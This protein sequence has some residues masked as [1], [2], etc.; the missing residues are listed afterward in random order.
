MLVTRSRMCLLAWPHSLLVYYALLGFCLPPAHRFCYRR[1]IPIRRRSPRRWYYPITGVFVTAGGKPV[2]HRRLA[3]FARGSMNRKQ[4]KRPT[5][6]P[7]HHLPTVLSSLQLQR[8]HAKRN[9]ITTGTNFAHNTLT[10]INKS[11][12]VLQVLR[13]R[14]WTRRSWTE[15]LAQCGGL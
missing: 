4:K 12:Q 6:H 11:N 2:Y 7:P 3:H 5:H 15:S 1:R 8:A 14:S 13:V 9:K 10:R